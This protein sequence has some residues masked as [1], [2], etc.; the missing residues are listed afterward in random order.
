VS[1]VFEQVSYTYSSHEGDV[2]ALTDLTLTVAEGQ[3]LGVIGHTGSGKS[4]LLQLMGGLMA[5]SAGRVLLDGVDLREK[6]ARQKLY[7]QVGIAFQYPEY[8]LFA[9]TVAEDIAFAPR[10]AGLNEAEIDERV[11]FAMRLLRLDYDRFASL[12]PF[13]LSGGE[14]R[15]VALAGVLASKPRLLILDEP[16]AGL[17]PAGREELL[18]IVEEYHREGAGIVMVS[19]S[20]DDIARLA[21]QVLVLTNGIGVLYG[22]PAEVFSHA[23]ALRTMNLGVPQATAFATKLRD[24]GI[25]LPEGLLTI[26]ALADAIVQAGAERVVPAALDTA[27]ERVPAALDTASQGD[28]GEAEVKRGL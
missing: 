16:T 8:Q 3:F 4:T 18:A 2:T 6:R 14:M 10:N 9:R 12:S 24:G 11:R 17:D 13:E 28:D 7:T 25:P 5:P 1:L 22:P 27:A 19:H 15:R 20:M 23:E 21:D 26:E